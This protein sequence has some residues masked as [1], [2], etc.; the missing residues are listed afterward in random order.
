M[1]FET[2]YPITKDSAEAAKELRAQMQAWGE[3]K[4]V[5]KS[6]CW[7]WAPWY[8]VAKEHESNDS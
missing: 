3:W 7:F 2:R 4:S 6:T 1:V 8:N 5:F